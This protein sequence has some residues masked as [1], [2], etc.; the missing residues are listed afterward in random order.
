MSRIVSYV[1]CAVLSQ[2]LQVALATLITKEPQTNSLA[3][4]A[5]ALRAN[6][7]RSRRASQHLVQF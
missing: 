3:H 4:R 6:S 7:V 5:L 2:L 1:A